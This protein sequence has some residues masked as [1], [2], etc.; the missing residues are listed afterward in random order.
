MNNNNSRVMA[1]RLPSDVADNFERLCLEN[2]T[3]F[4]YVFQK[5]VKGYMKKHNLDYSLKDKP[6]PKIANGVPV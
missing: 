2:R 3:T 6:A 4:S 5:A 1:F